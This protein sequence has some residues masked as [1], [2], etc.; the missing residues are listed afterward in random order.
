MLVHYSY[1]KLHLGLEK[2]FFCVHDYVNN[3]TFWS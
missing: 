2:V 3:W 1:I